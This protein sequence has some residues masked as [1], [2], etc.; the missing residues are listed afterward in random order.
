MSECLNPA[1][2]ERIA[3]GSGSTEEREH[4]ASCAQCQTEVELLTAFA[5][6]SATPE[7]S[8]AVRAIES[9]LRAEPAWRPSPPPRKTWRFSR[10]VWGLALAGAVA[11]LFVGLS[12][13]NPARPAL[14]AEDTVRSLS[15]PLVAPLGDQA[16]P[17]GEFRWRE[18]EGAA[19]Y[20]LRLLDIQGQVIWQFRTTGNVAP[21]PPDVQAKLTERRTLSWQVSAI[22]AKGAPIAVS[23]PESFRVVRK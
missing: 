23:V 14:P 6:A 18:A 19:V 8:A 1:A 11:A 9:R 15:V 22:D 12:L 3:A 16:E 10:P 2:L 5:T 21:I 4:V 7:E 17:P 13:R 20:E